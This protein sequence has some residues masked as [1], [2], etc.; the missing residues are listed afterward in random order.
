MTFLTSHRLWL[1]I[2]V[3]SIG[4]V[5]AAILSVGLGSTW[6]SPTDVVRG[7]FGGDGVGGIIVREVRLPRVLLAGVVGGALAVAGV[8]FQA[9]LRNALAEPFILGISGG[10]GLG[11]ILAVALGGHVTVAG[12]AGMPIF[13][14]IG[15][16]LAIGMVY[17]FAQSGGTVNLHTMLLAGVVVNAICSACIMGLT[18]TIS[19]DQLQTVIFW[20]MGH[21]STLP[22]ASVGHLAIYVGLGLVI[23]LAVSRDLNQMSLGESQAAILGTDV[24]WT[25]RLAF[26]GASLITGGAVAAAGLVG[27]VGLIV[28]HAM[29][30]LVGPDHRLLMPASFIGGAAFLMIADAAA[31]TVIAPTE[32]PVGVITALVGG[33]AFLVLLIRRTRR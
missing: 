9:L 13:A 21:L 29:R 11:A 24:E 15:A 16:F 2:G 28:P 12:I 25:K 27:F 18:V 31:R 17:S 26:L 6:V 4:L 22:L 8:T 5:G 30:L 14:F 23:L 19:Y 7:L 10:A 3:L 1:W 32:L 20:L 33:P